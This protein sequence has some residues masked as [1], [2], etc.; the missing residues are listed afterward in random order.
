MTG[1]LILVALLVTA[2]FSVA[3]VRLSNRLNES[4]ARVAQLTAV[5]EWCDER[6][7]YFID[8]VQSSRALV[9]MGDP[10]RVA[11]VRQTGVSG[12][13]GWIPSRLGIDALETY[14]DTVGSAR[15]VTLSALAALSQWEADNPVPQQ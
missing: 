13:A 7:K 15:E 2:P 6:E 12:S 11:L 3:V 4:R 9:S 5:L 1:W 8:L 10:S 14:V